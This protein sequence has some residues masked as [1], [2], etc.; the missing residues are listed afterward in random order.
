[1]GEHKNKK[2]GEK[3]KYLMKNKVVGKKPDSE[4]NTIFGEYCQ[5]K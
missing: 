1:M 5:G 3:N 4:M 2:N